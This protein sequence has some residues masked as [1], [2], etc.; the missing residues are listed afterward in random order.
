MLN[1]SIPAYASA[2]DRCHY[3]RF[4]P[5]NASTN[6]DVD[7][8][9]TTVAFFV[10]TICFH[11]G[12]FSSSKN[13]LLAYLFQVYSILLATLWSI[14]CRELSL[15][16]ATFVLRLT[17]SPPLMLVVLL[18]PFSIAWQII[19]FHESIKL[20][21][22]ITPI[23]GTLLIFLW[24]VLGVALRH[25]N[26][27]FTD[28]SLCEG[29]TFWGWLSD[30]VSIA[31][32]NSSPITPSI[33]PWMNIMAYILLLVLPSSKGMVG[34]DLLYLG[35]QGSFIHQFG[36]L[37]KHPWGMFLLYVSQVGLWAVGI[38]SSAITASG[39]DYVLTYGQMLS[40]LTA[41]PSVLLAAKSVYS[42][43]S[44]PPDFFQH[45]FRQR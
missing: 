5:L 4:Y 27:A 35:N 40:I 18:C 7:G 34:L 37:T 24:L 44:D 12:M 11:I 32:S 36:V 14:H 43:C 39:K 23:L 8:T 29:S 10:S 21:N 45:F 3:A 16:D 17:S 41:V 26:H 9:A 2:D 30:I 22:L 25:F 31:V 15:F 38:I 20:Q 19:T 28:G 1:Y 13:I 42:C 6:T 33:W